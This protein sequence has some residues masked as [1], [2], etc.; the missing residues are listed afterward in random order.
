MSSR[1]LLS[2]PLGV[3]LGLGLVGGWWALQGFADAQTTRRAKEA[4]VD[5]ASI[6]KKLHTLLENQQLILQKFDAVMEELRIVKIR[7]TQ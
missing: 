1:H 7:C 5:A 6:D 4:L 2:R 3:A